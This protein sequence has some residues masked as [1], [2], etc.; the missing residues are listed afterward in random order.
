MKFDRVSSWVLMVLFQND[1]FKRGLCRVNHSLQTLLVT[2]LIL[3][4]VSFLCLGCHDEYKLWIKKN[5]TR[6]YAWIWFCCRTLRNW[7]AHTHWQKRLPC[8][9]MGIETSEFWQT[10]LHQA[11]GALV[12]QGLLWLHQPD[13][14]YHLSP[15]WSL[16]TFISLLIP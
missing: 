14:R 12:C 4:P 15:F 7:V 6:P 10:W 11:V 1:A 9:S 8:G 5:L 13:C 2:N 16:R 3:S